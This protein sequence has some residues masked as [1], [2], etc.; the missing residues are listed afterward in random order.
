MS[1]VSCIVPMSAA[2]DVFHFNSKTQ[3]KNMYML[4]L[5]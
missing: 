1:H 5:E 4:C 2:E 3:Q